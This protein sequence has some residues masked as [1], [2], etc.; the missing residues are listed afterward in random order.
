[1]HVI[2]RSGNKET[3]KFDK[4]HNRIKKQT[5]GLNNKY[6]DSHSIAL[7]TFEG[8]YDNVKTKDV[9]NLVANVCAG[10]VTTHPDYSKLAARISISSLHKET[11]KQFSKV[12][13]DLYDFY[14][15]KTGERNSL[16]SDK[17]YE[18][19]KNHS[20]Q[21]EDV[22]DHDRDF[23]FDFFG[24]KVLERAYLLK[25][26]DE[27]VERPQHLYMRVALGIYQDRILEDSSYLKDA[28][29]IYERVSRGYFSFAT[30]TMFN[31]GTRRPQLA[32][33]FLMTTEDS[34]DGIFKNATRSAQ[35]SKNSGGIGIDFTNVR[36][37]GSYIRGTGGVS[38]GIVPMLR[39]F[40]EIGKYVNQGGKR[41]G[42]I[43]AYI[44]PWHPEIEDF[45]NLRKNHG[46]EELRARDIFTAIWVPDLFFK[47]LE[48]DENWSLFDPDQ[49]P[50]LHDLY[51]SPNDKAFTRRYLELEQEGCARRTVS[52]KHI[53]HK[54][55]ESIMETGVPYILAKDTINYKSNQKNLGSIR[56]SNLC[57]EIVLHTNENEIAVCNL[58]SIALN[59][60][61][62]TSHETDSRVKKI[63]KDKCEA[64]HDS[65]EH[66][67]DFDELYNVT[68]SV[69][70]AVNRVIDENYYPNEDAKR[71]NM[72]H[73]PVGIGVQGLA[74]LFAKLKVPFNSK[75]A[76][77]LNWKI[78]ETMYYA[79]LKASVDLAKVDG[80]YSTFKG[81]P[82]SEG[83][84]QFD[85]STHKE[86]KINKNNIEVTDER[87][88]QLSD[89]YDW[90]SLK[91]EI[92]EY[93]L[94][95]SQLLAN[96]PTVSSAKISGNHDSFEPF[97]N[98]IFSQRT[99]AGEFKVLNQHLVYDLESLGLWSE[100]MRDKL[101]WNKGSVQNI[102]SIPENIKN[103]YKTVWEYKL[104]D[105]ID[106]EADRG[107]FICQTQSFNLFFEELSL[108]RLTTAILYSWKKG[109]KTLMYYGRTKPATSALTG[110]GTSKKKSND[111]SE[112]EKQ[113]Y[114]K[115]LQEQKEK[116]ENGE[117]CEACTT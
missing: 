70:K 63:I 8:L 61:V 110:L 25:I 114:Q 55:F 78:S 108:P 74:D 23:N 85:L 83:I 11:K 2:N 97:S 41:K 62:K 17:L 34:I 32:S 76:R 26:N 7:K 80:P 102:D 33:C 66:V 60:F 20:D 18:I 91:K 36:S 19:V 52:A 58:S 100:D 90:D 84:L 12:V 21:I 37:N 96:M 95:N 115:W 64:E 46:K 43:A 101:I 103:V 105:L 86:L 111:V 109:N 72:K 68:Y 13:S 31:A 29:N 14:N 3:L 30:P 56:C 99:I 87:P 67:Y 69:T 15:N 51:D 81:S 117:D 5:Y 112:S 57:A 39:V 106:M 98:N 35:I 16:I 44:E 77:E 82:A 116:S 93:G 92:M 89:R 59:K 107:H 54:I 94:H 113:E 4:I 104:K 75:T 88:V 71:S 45:L 27:V 1:M 50:D 53:W 65:V 42:S 10:K 79:S 40:N 49:A 38:N 22:I 73:R 47:R 6:I 24:Y 9:D 28:F 48:N